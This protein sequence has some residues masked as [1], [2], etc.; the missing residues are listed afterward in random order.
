MSDHEGLGMPITKLSGVTGVEGFPYHT[1]KSNLPVGSPRRP[2][3]YSK[4]ISFVVKLLHF[5]IGILLLLRLGSLF[6]FWTLFSR[7]RFALSFGINS[8]FRFLLTL[9]AIVTI[10]YVPPY[11]PFFVPSLLNG[12]SIWIVCDNWE[13]SF[14]CW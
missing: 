13:C 6:L 11:M 2:P 8:I 9:K 5:P 3:L 7:L 1:R 10:A 14:H 4:G 12:R